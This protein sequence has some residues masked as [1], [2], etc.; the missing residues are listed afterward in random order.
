[1]QQLNQ[2]PLKQTDFIKLTDQRGLYA[3]MGNKGALYIIFNKNHHFT[4]INKLSD[5]DDTDNKQK[6][7]VRF[8]A[9]YTLFDKNG[10]VTDPSGI[11]YKGAWGQNRVASFLPVDYEENQNLALSDLKTAT[12]NGEQ[13]TMLPDPKL[14]KDS[15]LALKKLS[16]S[17]NKNNAPEKLYVQID[18]PYYA[19]DDTIWFKTYLF[20]AAY[21]TATAKSN[22]VY[23]DVVNDSNKIVKQYKWP[24]LYGLSWGNICLNEKDFA[25]GTYTLRA[26]TNW[27]RNFGA[28]YFFYKQ[29][30]ITD[31]NENNWLINKQ[32]NTTITPGN[33][34]ADV[35]LQF[36]NINKIPL[37]NTP[38][39]L[40]V[41][42]GEKHLYKQTFQTDKNGLLDVN[43]KLPEKTANLVIVAES[44]QKDK[45]ANFPI[46]LNRSENTDVQFLPEGGSL[47][48]GF[49]THIGF[50]AVGEDGKSVPISG[51][52]TDHANTRA[53]CVSVTARWDWE[54]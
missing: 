49:T 9:P 45:K 28:D 48:S 13:K 11:E 12:Q 29:F 23:I 26:Y 10:G 1:M 15:L 34:T 19:L 25:A 20:K 8:N 32:A 36:N 50:K 3:L 21:L 46:I 18:K 44:P 47:V 41:I 6:T 14:L 31:A 53:G 16:D 24:T 52:V 27:M 4:A 22:L 17:I 51:I 33:K 7:L 5:L 42:A 39:Q 40:Q 37:A 30:Y 35:K 54:F 2:S 38:L 43:F